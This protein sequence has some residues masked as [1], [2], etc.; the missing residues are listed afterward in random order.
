VHENDSALNDDANDIRSS[1]RFYHC[2]ALLAL[3]ADE[4]LGRPGA[5][6][7]LKK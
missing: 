7:V 3:N 5:G 4:E 2:G 1:D 6:D